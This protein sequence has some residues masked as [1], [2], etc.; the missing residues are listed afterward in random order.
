MNHNT[1]HQPQTGRSDTDIGAI[2]YT[3]TSQEHAILSNCSLVN[4][5][6][7]Q[8]N[9]S[10]A[11][12]NH[13]PQ[14]FTLS[15]PMHF[16]IPLSNNYTG[17]SDHESPDP[18]ATTS[19]KSSSI[20]YSVP[21]LNEEVEQFQTTQPQGNQNTPQG[22]TAQLSK[23]VKSSSE[24][25]V[26]RAQQQAKKEKCASNQCKLV[27]LGPHGAGKTATVRS[28]LGKDIQPHQPSAVSADISGTS[29]IDTIDCLY[30][31][32]WELIELPKYIQE[33]AAH[34]DIKREKQL[35]EILKETQEDAAYESSGL[36]VQ[37]NEA[38][39]EAKLKMVIYD[40]GRQEM[41]YDIEFLFLA[42]QDIILLTFNASIGLDEPLATQY[43]YEDFQ[44]FQKPYKIGRKQTNFQAIKATLH[45]IYIYCGTD[46]GNECEFISPRIPIVIMVATH[47][48]DLTKE[49]KAEIQNTLFERLKF[50]PLSDHFP[51]KHIID[52]IYFIDNEK[53]DPEAFEKLKKA[54]MKAAVFVRTDKQPI[55]YLKFNEEILR[56]SQKESMID[57]EK[58]LTI[59]KKYALENVDDTVDELL[60]Y[61]SHKGA[62]LHYSWAPTLKCSIFIS[63]QMVSN[64]VSFVFKTHN[65]A[66]FGFK[67]GLIKKFIR[68]DEFGLLE[69]ALLDD[70]L[71][72]TKGFSYTKERVLVFLEAFDLAVEVDR[73]TK[74]KNEKDSYLTP[75]SGRVFFVPSM[76][77]YNESK[78]YKKPIDHIDNVVFFHFPDEILPKIVFNYLLILT[79][80]SSREYGYS[81]RR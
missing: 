56:M 25:C 22:Q 78:D 19:T 72:R 59:A 26:G 6:V 10:L 3:G 29:T 71:E 13:R 40:I 24:S 75:D 48:S 57:K 62:I 4:H 39:P 54:V 79:F 9:Q 27:T 74:F 7:Y 15:A 36:K 53:K 16:E 60:Q 30:A 58:A 61:S 66:K 20:Y 34:H 76:L 73:K 49:K 28:L 2:Q 64:L 18:E 44:D 33:L 51:K 11:P 21:R 52:R 38:I 31:C 67:A 23:C 12:S 81:I 41:H 70:M 42:S 8:P 63:P 32:E 55:T 35:E 77:V 37:Q 50:S 68:F 43:C 45:D 69:E 47:A 46:C 14:N 5:N 17:T 1:Y 80:Q 65:Y